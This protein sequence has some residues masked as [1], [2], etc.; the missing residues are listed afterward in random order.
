[1]SSTK[2]ALNPL[3]LTHI[4]ACASCGISV[5]PQDDHDLVDRVKIDTTTVEIG[6]R[7]KVAA[8]RGGSWYPACHAM[9]CIE[10]FESVAFRAGAHGDLPFAGGPLPRTVSNIRKPQPIRIG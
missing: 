6:H 3:V 5:M 10:L 7:N 4:I 8:D 9:H 2:D 1:M